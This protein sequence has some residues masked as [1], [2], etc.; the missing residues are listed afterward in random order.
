MIAFC[1]AKPPKIGMN[2]FAEPGQYVQ[3]TV[4]RAVRAFHPMAGLVA[5]R[6]V[7]GSRLC[8]PEDRCS[9]QVVRAT[10]QENCR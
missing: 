7:H 10:G 9:A 4:A 1:S 5:P 6:L 8:A 2:L 3:T